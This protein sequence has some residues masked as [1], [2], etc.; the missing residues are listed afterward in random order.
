M[1]NT[2]TPFSEHK[3]YLLGLVHRLLFS[4]KRKSRLIRF[5]KK[6]LRHELNSY[7]HIDI[8][9]NTTIITEDDAICY[10]RKELAEGLL[11][12]LEKWENGQKRF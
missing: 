8:N 7:Q 10:G 4:I 12:E 2:F 3:Q 1:K 11:E 5:V 9:D 6:Y